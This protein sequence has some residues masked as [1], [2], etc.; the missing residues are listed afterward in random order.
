MPTSGILATTAHLVREAQAGD[1]AAFTQLVLRYQDIAFATALSMLG[2]FGLAQD[3]VQE[4]F[5]AAY[6]NLSSLR[7]PSA[8]PAWMRQVVRHHGARVLRKRRLDAR[9]GEG[10]G[11]HD[12]DPLV[13]FES[14]ED[15]RRILEAIDSLPITEREITILYYLR[16]RTQKEVA[17][18]VDLPVTTVNSRLHAA[19]RRL[20][21]ELLPMIKAILPH[22]ALPRSFAE[23]VGEII[24]VRA[25]RLPET[26]A[27]LGASQSTNGP[28]E[29]GIKVLDLL[30]P[31]PEG[32]SI[33]VFG[34]MHVGKLV[35]I[36]ELT[37]NL[38]RRQSS[39]PIFIFVRNPDEAELVQRLT[40]NTSERL[41]AVFVALDDAAEP[42]RRQ[43][44]PSLDVTIYMS[45]HLIDRGIYPAVDP[46]RSSS[47]LLRD[48]LVEMEHAEVARR[49]REAIANSN[50]GGPDGAQ[51]RRISNFLSQ[52]FV[53]AERFT[54]RPG[55]FVPRTRTIQDFSLLASGAYDQ[56]AEDAFLMRGTL[57]GVIARPPA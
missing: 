5:L 37:R 23:R 48:G 22:R 45:R 54:N 15:L 55:V 18:L 8:F 3:T 52:P 46:I 56:V 50:G 24:R 29:T 2:D 17:A 51:G 16:D 30:C 12:L 14:R 27:E 11:G 43:A 44:E 13:T 53:V 21:G 39:L 42:A 25:D 57:D 35:L 19:R 10:N 1:V 40:E 9:L 34:D 26:L 4:A 36:D 41:P 31:I 6:L 20:K 38:A 32:G 28:I 49:V 7:A 47:R 33:G